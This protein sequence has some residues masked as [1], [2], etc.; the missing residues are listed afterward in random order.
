M[1]IVYRIVRHFYLFYNKI[2]GNKALWIED[3]TNIEFN[4]SC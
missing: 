1:A 3:N 2:V 4:I